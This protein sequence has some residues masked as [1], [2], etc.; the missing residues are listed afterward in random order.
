MEQL[1]MII[2][3]GTFDTQSAIGQGVVNT[4]DQ[5]AY[6]CSAQTGST[7][8]L[9]NGTGR[10]TSTTFIIN[11]VTTTETA[12]GK[13]SICYRGKENFYGNIW[14]FVYGVN[15][16]GN[17]G[18]NGGIPYICTDYNYQENRTIGNYESVG[19]SI[20]NSNYYI[21]TF[22]YAGEKYDWVFFASKTSTTS[23][24]LVKDYFYVTSN[25]GNGTFRIARLGGTWADGANAGAFCW[26]LNVGVGVRSRAIGGSL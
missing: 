7:A 13:T 14:K 21:K 17:G 23:S 2:E 5:S 26:S 19:F 6:N 8:S 12:N 15:I 9:G 1:L 10:A 22:G 25:L 3:L 20:A 4:T 11:G 18:A 24:S 16:K